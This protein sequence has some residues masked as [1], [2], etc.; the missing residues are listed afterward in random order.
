[1][2]ELKALEKKIKIAK[3][4]VSYY[5]EYAYKLD[6]VLFPEERA[7]MFEKLG[8]AEMAR[9]AMIAERNKLIGV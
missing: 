5:L 4:H 7:R 1:M 3:N 9:D 8:Q 6:P 2:N